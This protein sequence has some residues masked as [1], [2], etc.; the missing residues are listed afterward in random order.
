MFS[1][2]YPDIATPTPKTSAL[3]AKISSEA[4]FDTISDEFA[5]NVKVPIKLLELVSID[6]NL[7][8]P[9]EFTSLTAVELPKFEPLPE[10]VPQ[11]ASEPNT[12]ILIT[13]L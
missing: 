4:S 13:I 6:I 3:A 7:S 2:F 1:Y 11:A 9:P 8:V 5:F 12:L 10:L